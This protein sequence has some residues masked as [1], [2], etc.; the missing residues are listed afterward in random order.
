MEDMYEKIYNDVFL[1]ISK[2]NLDLFLCGGAS[3][4]GRQSYRDTIRLKLD[5]VDKINV[6]YPEDLF[7]ELLNRKKYDL[8]EL[9]DFLAD[10]SDYIVIVSESPGSFAELGAFANNINTAAKSIVFLQTKYK[11]ARSFINQGPVQH[12]KKINKSNILYFNESNLNESVNNLLKRIGIYKRNGI[13]INKNKSI[14]DIDIISG[15]LLFILLLLYFY[16]E[17]EAKE[18]AHNIKNIYLKKFEPKNFDMIYLASLRRLFSK[19]LVCKNRKE[20]KFYYQ[21]SDKGYKYAKSM[22]NTADIANRNKILNRI[23]LEII[24]A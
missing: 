22:L 10:N 6:L 20:E 9:E 11:S 17:L 15:Q 24:N 2:S 4:K 5:K 12:I 8:L 19:G 3:T 16:V 1:H 14:K 21:L 7:M 18:L 13:Y 23:R